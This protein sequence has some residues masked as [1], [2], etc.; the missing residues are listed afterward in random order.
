[1]YTKRALLVGLALTFVL[2]GIAWSYKV[3][4]S[5]DSATG[6]YTY[7]IRP[8]GSDAP[9]RDFH[10]KAPKGTKIKYASLTAP[11][12]SDNDTGLNPVSHVPNPPAAAGWHTPPPGPSTA[13]ELSW[14]TD[15]DDAGE[16][17]DT[18]PS[19]DPTVVGRTLRVQIT[20]GEDAETRMLKFY[21]TTNGSSEPPTGPG[22]GEV[23]GPVAAITPSAA[24]ETP[25]RNSTTAVT[26]MCTENNMP[27]QVYL[28]ASLSEPGNP[29]TD[30]LGIGINTNDPIPAPH[31]VSATPGSGVFGAPPGPQ[32]VQLHVG[33]AP[34][35]Y[36]FYLV[37][38]GMDGETIELF[39]EP[40]CFTVE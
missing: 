21:V 4:Q 17:G 37:A 16:E 26:V 28:A 30:P 20:R 32:I 22:G 3:T 36:R 14:Y 15:D 40:L 18:D 34:V 25:G 11:G 10:L 38:V 39:S 31:D 12:S 13:G 19:D 24:D 29:A 35:G 6:V 2:V 1:M 33:P 27:W 23:P 5:Y 8:Q 9:V 7:D